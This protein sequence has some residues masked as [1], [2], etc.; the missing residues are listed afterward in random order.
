MENLGRWFVGIAFLWVAI[1]L[2][3]GLTAGVDQ[4]YAWFKWAKDGLGYAWMNPVYLALGLFIVP[5]GML[6]FIRDILGDPVAVWVKWAAP[7]TFLAIYAFFLL[8]ALPEIGHSFF[9]GIESAINPG[10]SVP[11]AGVGAVSTTSW[12]VRVAI[13]VA[14]LG[15]IPA[16]IGFVVGM[17]GGAKGG[18]RR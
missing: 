18:I 8:N 11:P 15:G 17:A 13:V 3:W 10:A 16:V 9:F 14:V 4:P 6:V 1:I 5:V 2:L 7:G 12:L